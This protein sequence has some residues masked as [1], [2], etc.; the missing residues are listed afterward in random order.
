MEGC[1]NDQGKHATSI[2]TPPAKFSRYLVFQALTQGCFSSISRLGRLSGAESRQDWIKPTTWVVRLFKGFDRGRGSG[3]RG[4]G[5]RERERSKRPPF[6]S[7]HHQHPRRKR[8]SG[9][10][11]TQQAVDRTAHR[12][13][14]TRTPFKTPH[15]ALTSG[16]KDT[17]HADRRSPSLSS[18][19]TTRHRRS[20]EGSAISKGG[21]PAS[22]LHINT[23]RGGAVRGEA[24]LVNVAI[25]AKFY[26]GSG[27]GYTAPNQTT[28]AQALRKC[29]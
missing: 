13:R 23:R 4:K 19:A 6:V 11:H 9:D 3:R 28:Q 10:T 5:A 16:D 2:F 27:C 12:E 26:W 14:V 17:P 1:R 21:T 7:A 24:P 15:V 20:W 22:M 25:C 29:H 18:T 8:N